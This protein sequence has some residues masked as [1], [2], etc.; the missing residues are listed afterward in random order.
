[1]QITD[2]IVRNGFISAGQSATVDVQVIDK[3]GGAN[4]IATTALARLV[5]NNPD[6]AVFAGSAFFSEYTDST[7]TH[8]INGGLTAFLRL[9]RVNSVTVVTGATN[10]DVESVTTVWLVQSQ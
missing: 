7:G 9:S 10:A 1:M 2:I 5:K 4:I 6:S 8:P 3:L